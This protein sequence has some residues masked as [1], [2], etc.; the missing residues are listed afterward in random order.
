[1]SNGV[2]I[3]GLNEFLRSLERFPQ[4][5]ERE[6]KVASDRTLL[7]AV[8]WIKVYPPQSS[9]TTYRR[10]RTLGR[11]WTA[12]RPTWQ[13]V[14]GGFSGR[15]SNPVQY[16]PYVQAD[17]LQARV[18]QGRWRTDEQAAQYVQPI[19]QREVD[20]AAERVSSAVDS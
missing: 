12:A 18:H 9:T 17:G 15:I 11:F 10:T 1:M 6:L 4:L 2:R 20:A 19:A 13:N 7:T 16:A 5:A 14:A 3:T 8:A